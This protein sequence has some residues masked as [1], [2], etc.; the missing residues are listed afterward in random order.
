MDVAID[1][2]NPDTLY[3]AAYQRRCRGWGFSG[4]SPDSSRALNNLKKEMNKVKT[5]LKKVPD[6]PEAISEHMNAISKELSDIHI[7]L[8]GDPK[9][10]YRGMR[11]SVRGSLFML[12]GSIGGYT[13]APSARQVQQIK[14]K[15]GELK[16]LIEKINKIIEN[17]IPK[18]NKLLNENNIPHL[19]PGKK[20]K[21][22]IK[23]C[24]HQFRLFRQIN[25]KAKQ[26]NPSILPD[27]M[28]FSNL[29]SS[30]IFIIFHVFYNMEL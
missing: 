16:V 27:S 11:F 19:F 18:L 9:L 2:E 20:I 25:R 4:G 12:G 10:S 7:K 14:E 13:G 15:S 6:V 26:P 8:I 30:N 17:D 3:A 5:I 28:I 1:F 29:T 24:I 23:N 22:S 21:L